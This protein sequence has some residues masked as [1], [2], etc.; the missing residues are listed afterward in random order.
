[1]IDP[2]TVKS[3]HENDLPSDSRKK[4]QATRTKR[5]KKSRSA[6]QSAKGRRRSGR[7]NHRN[8]FSNQ[9]DS[10]VTGSDHVSE[11][12][13]DQNIHHNDGHFDHTIVGGL[14]AKT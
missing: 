14:G 13:S 4:K 9:I 2:T 6:E 12:S 8:D 3:K 7:L 10:L 1:M 11:S 5:P